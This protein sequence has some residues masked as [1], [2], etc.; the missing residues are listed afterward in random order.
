MIE[1]LNKGED[2]IISIAEASKRFNISRSKLYRMKDSGDI[3]FSKRLDGYMGVEIS[4]LSRVFG[5]T[6]H[7]REDATKR[8]GTK[9]DLET[10]NLYLKK[11]VETL[12]KSLKKSEERLDQ[13]IALTQEQ[14]KR[15][16][17]TYH[18]DRKS[19]WNRLLG[20]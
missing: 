12:T 9:H 6:S 11:E 4:E 8:D 5:A 20:Q 3:S 1:V 15:F 13:F 14:N 10:E 7:G 2:M 18:S 17:L 16:L 19:L